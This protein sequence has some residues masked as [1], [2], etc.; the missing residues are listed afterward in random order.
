MTTLD[1]GALILTVAA[2]A[3]PA[4]AQVAAFRPEVQVQV[5]PGEARGGSTVRAT[6]RLRLPQNGHVQ[7]KAARPGADS[8]VAGSHPAGRDHSRAHH[9]SEGVVFEAARGAT[10]RWRCS[11]T[12]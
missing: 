2:T 7:S 10:S 8:D 9:V 1:I 3:A 6:V 4:A 12:S 11:A 5:V